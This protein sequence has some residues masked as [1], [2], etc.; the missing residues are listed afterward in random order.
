MAKL[1]QGCIFWFSNKQWIHELAKDKIDN[2]L[3][4]LTLQDILASTGFLNSAQLSNFLSFIVNKTLDDKA[5]EIKGYT[6]GV[7]ALGRAED[8]DPQ[9]DPSVRVM[10][11][12]LRQAL[13]NYNNEKGGF[14]HNSKTLKIKLIKGSYVPKF[15]FSDAE[16]KNHDGLIALQENDIDNDFLNSDTKSQQHNDRLAA[17]GP[18][19]MLGLLAASIIVTAGL[20]FSYLNKPV[21]IA[22][23][24]LPPKQIISLE[25]AV[26]PSI[27][28]YT[29]YSDRGLPDWAMPDEIHSKTV[30]S[31]SRF[32]EYRLLDI[33][34]ENDLIF[35]DQYISDYYLS[36]LFA[37]AENETDLNVYI[38]LTRPPLSEVIYSEKLTFS[39]PINGNEE[40]NIDHAFKKISEIMSPYGVIHGDI[41]NNES[42]PA[43]LACIRAIY[44][45]F[46]K[47]DL[48]T[49]ADGLDCAK[50]ATSRPN[51]SSSMYAMMTFLYVEA[52]RKQII[53]VSNQPLKEAEFYAKKSIL[54]DPKN[55]RAYQALFAVEKTLGNTDKAIAASKKAIELNPF[56]RDILAD[57]ATYLIAV[58]QQEE[59]APV[60]KQALE[61]IPTPPAWLSFYNFIHLDQIGNHQDADALATNFIANDSPLISIAVILSAARQGDKTR[62]KLATE[63]L[64][65]QQPNFALNPTDALLRHGFD[66]A[67][68]EELAT[69]LNEAGL[70]RVYS[71]ITN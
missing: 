30:L 63:T 21:T 41:A 40:H 46:Y 29:N 35:M 65:K 20:A 27:T 47:E 16:F 64:N 62:L 9:T 7:D 28:L 36:I 38:T 45:Y 48:Q 34:G 37:A 70:A 43:R 39:P 5:D 10:A 58:D 17:S 2:T 56:D 1:W 59:A 13:E 4:E 31:F 33:Q 61:L 57:Y 32:N 8:F 51:A 6:I 22:P 54:L 71:E 49:F 24:T 12:R 55:A 60:L 67:L 69:R 66:K 26:L 42:P 14:T 52:Y 53:E 68:A 25:D 44:N 11:G 15:E 19:W 18:K 23:T 3:V 50:R